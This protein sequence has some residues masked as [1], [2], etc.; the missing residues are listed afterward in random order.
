M[1]MPPEEKPLKVNSSSLTEPEGADGKLRR[2]VLLAAP[3]AM[4]LDIVGPASVFEAVNR[5]PNFRGPGCR[6]ELVT[7]GSERT[8]SGYLGISLVAHRRYSEV[9]GEVDTLLVVGGA[10][11]RLRCEDGVLDWLREM[12]PRVRRLG[13]VCTGAFLLATTGLLDGR[14][15]TTHWA[16]A[17]ELASEYPEVRVDPDPIWVQDGNVYTSAGVTA[18]MDLALAL[19]EE[20]YGAD[21]ALAVARTLVLFLRRPGGQAQFSVSL[22]A[23]A[24][25]KKPLLELQ[26]WM[27][28]NLNAD[29]SVEALAERSAMSPR[30]FARVFA[31]EMG[32]TPAR[33]VAKLRLEAARRR[34]EQTDKGME[35]IASVCGFASAEQMRRAFVRSLNVIPARYRDHFRCSGKNSSLAAQEMQ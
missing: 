16:W 5:I 19:V 21:I 23:Q 20:D 17:H 24:A 35:E 26:A 3:P 28:E 18:G 10:G 11:A 33:Y 34:L 32:I 31:E 15:A 25:E 13:S 14:R 7:T 6:V 27:A 22:S 2:I 29:L 1:K 4:E 12:A 8:I 9:Q 30:N